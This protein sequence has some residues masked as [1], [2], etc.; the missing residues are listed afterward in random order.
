MLAQKL[1]NPMIQ[2]TDHMKLNKKEGPSVDASI[3]VRKGNK[4]IMG[5]QRR[6]GPGCE[7]GEKERKGGKQSGPGM[8]RHRREVQRAR[9]RAEISSIGKWGTW[10]TTRKSQH[11]RL[12]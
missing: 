12:S 11:K 4:I 5:E 7:R 8:E 2:V 6:E 9:K 1:R 3:P 10:G